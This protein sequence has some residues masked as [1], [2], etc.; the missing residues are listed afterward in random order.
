MQRQHISI[1][2]VSAFSLIAFTII[3][4]G[5]WEIFPQALSQT[6][7]NASQEHVSSAELSAAVEAQRH[8]A[9]KLTRSASFDQRLRKLG[10]M[11]RKKGTVPVI[12]KVRAAFRPEGLMSN[13]AERLAQRSVIREAQDRLL[14]ELRYVPFTPK[15]YAYVPYVAASV[16]AAG[17][18]QLQSSSEA[19]DVNVDAEMRLA[20]ADSLPLV[21]ATRAWAGGFKGASK[22]IAVLDSGVDKNHPSLAGTVVSEAC[23]STNDPA[24]GYSSLC[25]GDG[26]PST[27][28]GSGVHCTVL[29]GIGNCGHGTHM[30]GIAAGRTGVAYGANIISIQVMSLVNDPGACREQ[31]S[32]LLARTSDVI[33]ALNRVYELQTTNTFDIA[34][35]NISLAGD[36]S[37]SHCDAEHQPMKEIIDLLRSVNIATVVAAGNEFLADALSYPACISSAVSVGAAG[38]GSDINTP[39]N[40]VPQF[41]N[42]A[43]FL[44]LLAPGDFITSLAPGGGFEGG[45][46]TSMAAAHVSGAWAMLKGKYPTAT[47]DEVLNKLTTTGVNIT[48]QRNNVTKSRIQIDAALEVNIP[49]ETWIGR[50]YNNRNLEGGSVLERAEGGGF[51]DRNF[52]GASPAPGVSTENYSIS[53]TRTL[54]LTAGNYRF[55]VTGDDGVRLYIDGQLKIDKWVNQPAT[56]YNVVEDLSPGPHEI[57]LEYYQL[58]GPAQVRL[59]WGT[60]NPTCSQSVAADRWKG[61]YFN[62]ANLAGDPVMVQDN[63]AGF[64][65]F[66]WGGDGPNS[67]CNLFADY[68]S[69]RWTRT[70]NF[71][72]GV[73]R[74]TVSGD[75]VAWLWIDNQLRLAVGGTN[76]V[77][78]QLSLGDHVIRLEHAENVGVAS[79]SLSWE[80]M[81]PPSNLVATAV[82]TSQ[83]NLSWTD[84]SSFED[85][86][87]IER[88]NGSS[89][90]QINT[91]GASVRTYS[92]FGLAPTTTY[93]YRVRAFNSAGDS[94]YSNESFAT[95]FCSYEVSPTTASFVMSGGTGSVTV[96]P[97]ASCSWSAT[98]N[99][100][101]LTIT[102]GASGAGN[103]VVNY[104]VAPYTTWE[105]A[106]TATIT[107]GDRTVTITQT[108]PPH[109]CKI[110]PRIC[111]P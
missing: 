40:G 63:G 24:A 41:S 42:S 34:A 17:L 18:E 44:D 87:K 59:I 2:T 25:P 98:S 81:L 74:F 11:A 14:A 89:Y 36:T 37:M 69:A 54:S 106:R 60:L 20:T 72:Q 33:S 88:W 75:D 99:A 90:S 62:N 76:T 49:P 79:V 97:S 43:S 6:L 10:D 110:E 29:D 13:T 35:V 28:A 23:Y 32:C 48:D 12:I 46:G 50:Y 84:N 27:A 83:I 45:S 68:F 38:D 109:P 101:W 26:E 61:E 94:G 58:N 51:I 3:V 4:I 82:S 56:T 104:S 107:V 111:L 77:D 105:S 66:N 52:T 19:L 55:S 9:A 92:D 5:V 100:S 64:L 65:N 73:Y 103:G 57:R 67:A 93:W 80:Q 108:T 78:V 39:V 7:S 16:D 22:T 30:A 70:V 102:S 53:W 1:L 86:F 21:G 91:V 15:T 71:A 8:A 95:T 85:G 96:A 31:A 47:V